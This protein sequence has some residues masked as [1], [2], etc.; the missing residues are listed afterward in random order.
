MPYSRV[1]I[2]KGFRRRYIHP[3]V[4]GGCRWEGIRF[5]ALDPPPPKALVALLGT[6]RGIIHFTLS[7]ILS[8]VDTFQRGGIRKH[9]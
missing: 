9:L 1:F 5:R 6:S 3:A 8:E 7:L 4:K 2:A